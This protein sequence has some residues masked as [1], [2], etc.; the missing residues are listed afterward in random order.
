KPEV[1]DMVGDLETEIAKKADTTYVNTELGKKADTTYVNTELGKKAD[2][3]YVNTELGKKADTTYVNTELGKKADT[4]YVNTELG[5]KADTVY[6]NSEL[7]KKVDNSTFITELAK[8]ANITYVDEGTQ[9]IKDYIQ[10]RGMNLVTNGTGLLGDN[11]NWPGTEFDG[12]DTPGGGG[13][14]FRVP[15]PGLTIFSEE[16]LPVDINKQ[17]E[18]RAWAKGT[19]L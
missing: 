5:K 8:K 15:W 2:T 9:K 16:F 13:G 19:P 11:T 10:S 12:T 17:Y 4:T 1:D 6:V 7:S 18:V 14:S 3:T